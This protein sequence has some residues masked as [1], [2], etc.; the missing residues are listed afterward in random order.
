MANYNTLLMVQQQ[1]SQPYSN[2][3]A[4]C[5][6]NILELSEQQNACCLKQ[7]LQYFISSDDYSCANICEQINMRRNTIGRDIVEGNAPTV[8]GDIVEGNNTKIRLI[9]NFMKTSDNTYIYYCD[10][11]QTLATTPH[12]TDSLS[13]PLLI[14]KSHTIPQIIKS[15]F[16]TKILRNINV[17]PKMPTKL[18]TKF[19][20]YDVTNVLLATIQYKSSNKYILYD[21]YYNEIC[22]VK[23]NK[24]IISRPS[25]WSPDLILTIPT[26]PNNNDDAISIYHTMNPSIYKNNNNNLIH[27]LVFDHDTGYKIIK[28]KKNFIFRDNNRVILQNMRV[29]KNTYIT[30]YSNPCTPLISFAV[31]LIATTVK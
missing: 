10:T 12:T 5:S 15:L 11:Q 30:D 28:S 6:H 3:C 17:H 7:M 13:I 4:K 24:P 29:D 1:V 2:I 31:C 19:S 9:R 8:G 20:I 21:T 22:S 18:N 14:A 26:L 16:S 27:K 25:F 23:I